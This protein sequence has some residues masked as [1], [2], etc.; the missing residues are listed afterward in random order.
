M[1]GVPCWKR[2]I[3]SSQSLRPLMSDELKVAQQ[4]I[5]EE[6]PQEHINKVMVNFTKHLIAYMA[7]AASGGH[8]EH[9]HQL[10][11]PSPSL[12]PYFITNTSSFQSHQQTSL[13]R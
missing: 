13:Y 5:W 3:D 6:L 9:L 7:V 8:F 10:H 12:H 11:C 4:T 1:S 2:T